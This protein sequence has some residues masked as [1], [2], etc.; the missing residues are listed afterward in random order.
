MKQKLQLEALVDEQKLGR[1][2]LALLG[3]SFLAMF[4]DGF[5]IAALASAAP[6]MMR[7][8]GV[9]PQDFR[10]ALTASLFGILF[11]AP[12]LG[13]LGDR[14]G[15]RTAVI[16]GSV[17]F[18]LGTLGTV[19]AGDLDHV[20]VLRLLTGIGIGGLMPNLVALSSELSPRRWRATLI[21][22]MFTG[23][24]AGSGTPGTIQAWLI[25][26]YGWRIMFWIGGL[27]PLAVAVLLY[28]RLP[29]SVKYLALHPRRRAELL[30]TLRRM[31]PDLRIEDDAQILTTAPTVEAAG[32]GLRQL[33]SGA[34]ALMTPLLWVCFATALMAHYFMTSWLPLIFENHGLTSEEAGIA[35]SLYH[36]GGMVG[37]LLV[38]V[39]LARFGFAVIATLFLFAAPAIAALGLP[40]NAYVAMALLSAL[41]GFFVLGA[42]FGNNA[43]SGLMYPTAIRSRG[44]GWALGVGRFG[45]IVGPFFGAAL[46]AMQLP[47]H[48]LFMIAAV[49]MVVGVVSAV[50]LTFSSFRSSGSLQLDDSAHR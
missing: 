44:V 45:S 42:Q 31:R 6:G 47:L 17:I 48:Q 49:P 18:G 14:R 39:L 9:Q 13:W 29:E 5:D 28:F 34:L 25:P 43:S 50:F 32:S 37:G 22:L 1:F 2:N 8:W 36:Y 7:D 10:L 41:A 15:R 16:A 21:V 38:S 20:I 26:E 23:I 19:W 40:G 4:A 3:W 35:T 24:T 46:I 12:L 33:F 30:A 27:V 11:G